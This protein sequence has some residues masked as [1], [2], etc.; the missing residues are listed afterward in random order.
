MTDS[1]V[2]AQT[3][4]WINSV[5]IG[6]NFCP[7]AAKAVLRKSI[8]Y[9][10]LQE[11]TL[12]SA[13]ETLVDELNF[14]D[15]TEDIETTLLIFPKHFADFEDYL[16]LVELAENLSIEQGYEGVYQI[17]SFHPDYCFEGADADDPANY[18]NRSP[19]PMLHLL[20]EDSIS[21]ALD[22]YIDPEGIPERNIA[23]AQEK[24]LRYMQLLRAACFE[25]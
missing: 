20:R 23:F 22:H 17:A 10:V 16:D 7:F 8:R 11:T 24:G 12:E 18:T 25:I 3:T 5:V 6:C 15:R 19:Y 21:K 2:I 1:A 9:V 14:L 13:L 4:Q